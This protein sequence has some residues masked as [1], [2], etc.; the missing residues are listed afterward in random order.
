MMELFRRDLPPGRPDAADG[1]KDGSAGIEPLAVATEEPAAPAGAWRQV[2]LALTGL[3]APIVLILLLIAFFTWISGK[4]LDGLL[5]AVVASGLAWD[6]GRRALDRAASGRG[7]Q[8]AAQPQD[9]AVARS[10]PKVRRPGLLAA[11]ALAAA[12]SY[13][14]VV[15]SFSRYSWPAT[16]GVVGLGAA[17]VA[18]GWLGP[19]RHRPGRPLPVAG[20]LAWAG[21]LVAGGLWELSS[22]LQQPNLT[23]GSYAHPTV[24]TLTDPL[25][26]SHLGRSVALACWLGIGWFLVER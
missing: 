20:T 10:W 12:A 4:P 5:L 23:T 16:V 13:A 18:V 24:S 8:E 25:L 11:A 6:A 7:A 22:L 2:V 21:L 17:V 19:L 26:A 9:E 15:G 14:A 3:R 1:R